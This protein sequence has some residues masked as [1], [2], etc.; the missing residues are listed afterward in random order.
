MK[1]E[2]IETRC[3]A[4]GCNAVIPAVHFMCR[5][6]MEHLPGTLKRE[7]RLFRTPDGYPDYSEE[8]RRLALRAALTV[9]EAEADHDLLLS[10][11]AAV[12]A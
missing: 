7:I 2:T 11:T 12:M 8:F 5:R 1:L 9:A 4:I 6:H 3:Y 10:A